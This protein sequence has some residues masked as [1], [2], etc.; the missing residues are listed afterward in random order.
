MGKMLHIVRATLTATK[1]GHC[2]LFTT[3]DLAMLTDSVPNQSFS[4]LLHKATKAGVLEK[5]C[6]NIFIN[7]LSPPEGRGV[8]HKIASILHWNKFI[9]I[10][11][12]SQLSYLGV[13]SQVMPNQLTLMTTGRSGSIKTKYGIIEFTH[14][15]R[16]LDKINKEVYFDHE[17]GAFRATK[18]KAIMDLK[19]VGRNL[20]MIQEAE[21]AE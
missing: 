8:L 13:I 4:K 11:L 10:S 14:T 16:S 15:S 1:K 20:D 3:Q 12:E 6:K 19:R 9:Y 5:V 21:N 2:G 17:I 7:P 18:D